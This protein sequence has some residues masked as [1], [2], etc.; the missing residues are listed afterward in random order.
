M[1]ISGTLFLH[2]QKAKFSHDVAQMV[3]DARG[4]QKSIDLSFEILLALIVIEEPFSG[5][6]S[7]ISIISSPSISLH[8]SKHRGHLKIKGQFRFCPLSLSKLS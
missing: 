1:L 8:Y 6:C 4:H 7:A 2:M 3:V 5:Q